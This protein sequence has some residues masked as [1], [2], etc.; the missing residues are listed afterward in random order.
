MRNRSWR[1]YQRERAIQKVLFQIKARRDWWY[2][3]SLTPQ[4][5]QF[6][7]K[8][9]Y[10]NTYPAIDHWIP[11]CTWEEVFAMRREE[12]MLL[13]KN[14]KKCSCYVCGNPRQWWNKKDL[15]ERIAKLDE[16]EQL[17]DL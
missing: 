3:R 5:H 11:P 9:E 13:F 17:N 14:R 6:W 16:E 12:A 7:A 1:R 8:E 2:H 10:I 15:N 4:P